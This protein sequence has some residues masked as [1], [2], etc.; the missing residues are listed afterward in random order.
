MLF[1]EPVPVSDR[2]RCSRIK[3]CNFWKYLLESNM[4]LCIGSLTW[5]IEVDSRLGGERKSSLAGRNGGEL[6]P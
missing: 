2:E 4:A 3:L 1:F 6:R 5:S